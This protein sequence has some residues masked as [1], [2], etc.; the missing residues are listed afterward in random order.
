M[1]NVQI[2]VSFAAPRLADFATLWLHWK[3]CNRHKA[4]AEFCYPPP[5]DQSLAFWARGRR[6]RGGVLVGASFRPEL[7]VQA[8]R[9]L[10]QMMAIWIR[11]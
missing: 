3:G 4:V 6:L 10:S 2:N 11:T 7:R 8:R 1:L 5:P 9:K